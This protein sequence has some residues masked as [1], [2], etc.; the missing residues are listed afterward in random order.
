MH[1]EYTVKSRHE[2]KQCYEE[3]ARTAYGKADVTF[4]YKRRNPFKKKLC[5]YYNLLRK[6]EYLC[7]LRDNCKNSLKRKIICAQIKRTDIK[8]NNKGLEIGVEIT[9]F[10]MRK[11]VRICHPNVIINGFVSGGCVFHGHN[12]IGD[13]KTGD[14]TAVPRIEK[15]VD[16]GAGAII[17]GDIEIADGCIIG[18]GAVVTRSFTKPNCVIAGIPAK[19][20]SGESADE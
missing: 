16:I 8:K 3:N 1:G 11:P 13:K 7:Y 19:V 5:E 14:K 9:P 4:E 12:V 6:Y 18:A 10:F 15:N 20:I 17:I 2:L